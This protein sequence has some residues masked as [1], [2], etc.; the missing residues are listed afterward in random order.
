MSA[1]A[2]RRGPVRAV[3]FD[4]WKTLVPLPDEVKRQAFTETAE[5][6]GLRPE[7]LAE[8]WART[9]VRRETGPLDAYLDGLRE[10]LGGRWDAAQQAEAVRVRRTVH[11]RGFARPADGAV[12]T[13]SALNALGVPVGLVS[14]CS[15]DVRDMLDG[16][17]L[18][19]LIDVSVLS[20]EA[21][22][23]KP[24]PEVFLLAARRLGVDAGACL[25]VGDGHDD[26]LDGASVAG[27]SA[28]LLDLG[29]DHPWAGPRIGALP[30]VLALAGHGG[31]AP[32]AAWGGT[33][34]S[35]SDRSS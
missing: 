9:R 26:E 20:A 14:N 10:E 16:S 6:L 17:E 1:A 8:P 35:R 25:Y 19:P 27:M 22:L 21:G 29:E 12:E 30:E 34:L 11:G 7:E 24:D 3:V 13:L 15:S 2:P 32:D 18:G 28:V 5:A 23:M 4:L 33:P 31:R